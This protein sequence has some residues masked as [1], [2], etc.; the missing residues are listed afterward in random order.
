MHR[1]TLK[2]NS[3]KSRQSQKD[4]ILIIAAILSGQALFVAWVV[5]RYIILFT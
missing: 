5:S 1:R 4:D 3:N 2:K